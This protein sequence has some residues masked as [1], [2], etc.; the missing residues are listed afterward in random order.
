MGDGDELAEIL[1]PT[2]YSA[3]AIFLE[4]LPSA[5]W[6][7]DIEGRYV[8]ANPV[9]EKI[10][11]VK[12]TDLQGRT[13]FDLFSHETALQF[14]E[15]DRKAAVHGIQTIETLVQ[16]DGTA[17]Q[18]I[19]SKF[20][21]KDNHTILIAGIAI[22]I[23]RQLDVLKQS[24]EQMEQALK[25][26]D[27]FLAI[28]SHELKTPVTSIKAFLQALELRMR[29]PASFDFENN[30]RYMQLSIRQVDRLTVIIND[31]LDIN[32]IN[33]GVL[34]YNFTVAPIAPVIAEVMER[35]AVSFPSHRLLCK[36][37]NLTPKAKVD[38]VRFE[39]VLTNLITNAVK[40]SPAGSSVE[41]MMQ[42]DAHQITIEVI[43]YGIGISEEEQSHIFD[44]HYRT[45]E[46]L[47]TR[48]SGLGIGLYIAQQLI[49]AHDGIITVKSELEKG[50]TFTISI[51]RL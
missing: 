47:T 14:Q 42:S 45:K 26:R 36:L 49:R 1:E 32:K 23:T 15:N 4:H 9:A 37:S 38:L 2:Q 24:E 25:Q 35:M 17:H 27:G 28:A 20:P 40:Y 50:S 39:Q 43:D 44:Q 31:L 34:K 5:A 16:P 12:L 11:G 29:N 3:F 19:V 21:I 8:Y 46:A 48:V 33:S 51:P 13:D 6:I 7:K 22:D 30:A 41:V 18:S 10:F